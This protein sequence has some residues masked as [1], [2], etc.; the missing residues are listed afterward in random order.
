MFIMALQ[1][2]TENSLSYDFFLS[3]EDQEDTK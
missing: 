1:T 2:K 3:L